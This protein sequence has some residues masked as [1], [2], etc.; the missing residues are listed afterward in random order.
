[1]TFVYNFINKIFVL[2]LFLLL[3]AGIVLGQINITQALIDGATNG[4]AGALTMTDGNDYILTENVALTGDWTNN[5][6]A[7]SFTHGGFTVTFSGSS[8]QDILGTNTT[9]FSGVTIN[10]STMI[11]D[12]SDEIITGTLTVANSEGTTGIYISNQTIGAVIVS[13]G[14]LRTGAGSG[15]YIGDVTIS[16]GTLSTLGDLRVTGNW[17]KTSGT[18][19]HNSKSTS[20]RGAGGTQTI[21]GSTTFYDLN[22]WNTGGVIDATGATVVVANRLHVIIGKFIG[23]PDVNGDLTIDVGSEFEASGNFTLAGEFENNDTFDATTNSAKITFDGSSNQFISG[24]TTF[25]DVELN[26]ST[27]TPN[28]SSHT[29][30]GTLTVIAG[31]ATVPTSLGGLSIAGGTVVLSG[32]TSISGDFNHSSG[33]FTQGG[34][35]VTMNGTAAQSMTGALSFSNLTINNT[36]VSA[37]VDA[38]GASSLAVS[39][40]LT[41]T[42]GNFKS[43]SDYTNVTIAAA[44]TLTL[45]GD[46]TVSGDWSN[47]GTL[48]GNYE[49][50]FDGTDTQNITGTTTFYNL[51][52]NNSHISNKVVASSATVIV[53]N[54]FVITD[55]IFSGAPDLLNSTISSSAG[56]LELTGNIKV[57]GNWSNTSGNLT[58]NYEVEFDGASSTITGATTFYNLKINNASNTINIST[59]SVTNLLTLT[60]GSVTGGTSYKNVTLNGGT[61]ILSGNTALSGNWIKSSGTF[62]PGSNEVEFTGASSTITGATSFY[63]LEINNASN[64][65]NISAHTVTNLLTITAGSVTGGTSY[66]NVTLN[67]G[68]FILSGNTTLTGSWTNSSG[69]FTPGSY[70]VEFT[71]AGS[72]ITGATTFYSLDINNASNT[73]NISA[74]SVSNTLTVT[75]GSVTGGTDYVNL[76]IAG[77]TFVLSGNTTISGNWVRTGGS[78]TPGSNKV[79][80][81]GSS[82][83]NIT[84]TNSFYDLTIANTHVSNKVN[85]S[86]G[87]ITVTNDLAVTDG[88]FLSASDYTNVTISV[89]ATLELSGNITVSGSWTNNGTFT[90]GSNAVTFDGSS[91]QNLLGATTFYQLVINNP[92]MT[93]NLSAHTISNKLTV[94]TSEGT[95]G[96]LTGSGT[97]PTV[98]I[99]AGKVIL[100]SGNITTLLDIDGGTVTLGTGTI[101][102]LD[103]DGGTTTSHATSGDF[104]IVDIATGSLTL[105]G[106]V[107]ISGSFTNA[108]DATTFIHNDKTITFDGATTVTGPSTFSGVTITGTLTLANAIVVKGDWTN[109][110]GTFTHGSQ[111]VTFSGSAAQAL[112]GGTNTFYNLTITSG[113]VVTSSGTLTVTTNLSV[114]TGTFVSASDYNNVTLASGTTL[115]LAGNITVSGTW[116]NNGGSLTGSFAVEFDG[117]ASQSIGGTG[118]TTFYNLTLNNSNGA[119]LGIGQRVNNTLTLTSGIITLGNFDLTFGD[120]ATAVAGTLSATKMIAVTGT[121]SVIKEFTGADP[122]LFLF[123]IGETSGTTEYSPFSVDLSGVT[124][125]GTGLVAVN[126]TDAAHGDVTG[127]D[128]L[129]RY[130]SVTQS[131]LTSFSAAIVGTYLTADIT[132]TEASIFGLKRDGG[133][134]WTNLGLVNAGANTI[135]GSGLTSFSDFTGGGVGVTVTAPNGGQRFLVNRVENI[136]WTFYNVTNVQID[137]STNNG[138]AWTPVIAST[139]AAAGT[140]AWTIPATLTTQ[141]LVRVSDATNAAVVNDVSNAVFTIADITVTTPNGAEFWEVA[142]SHDIEWDQSDLVTEVQIEYSTNT[143]GSW[144]V[145]DPSEV[146]AGT[147]DTFSWTIPNTPTATALVRVTALTGGTGSD[148]SDAVFIIP[149]VVVVAPNGGEAWVSGTS[150]DITYTTPGYTIGTEQVTITYS[151]DNGGS[152]MPLATPVT[153]GTYS[154]T[155]SDEHTYNALVEIKRVAGTS[156]DTSNAVFT[157]VPPPPPY[158]SPSAN[159]VAVTIEPTLTW[160]AVTNAVTYEMQVYSTATPS[161]TVIDTTGLLPAN[162]LE[163]DFEQ[164]SWMGGQNYY[165]R[166]KNLTGYLWRM[167]T[168]GLNSVVGNWSSPRKFTTIQGVTPTLTYPLTGSIL[169]TPVVQYY[170]NVTIPYNNLVFELFS[171]TTGDFT[172]ISGE[173]PLLINGELNTSGSGYSPGTLHYWMVRTKTH[174]GQTSSYS[175][176]ESFITNGLLSPITLL[177]PYDGIETFNN[178]PYVYWLNYLYSPLVKYQVRYSKNNSLDINDALDTDFTD[179]PLT[180]NSYAQLE[181][182]D[183]GATYY[184][185]VA[186][187]NDG[188]STLLWSDLF[189]FTTPASTSSNTF[190]APTPSYPVAGVTIYSTSSTYYWIPQTIDATLQYQ[191]RYGA[192]NA[193]TAGQLDA[194]VNTA[195]TSDYYIQVAGLTGNTTYYW[196]VRTY[197]GSS[198]SPWSVVQTFNTD[199]S[200]NAIKTPILLSPYDGQIVNNLQPTLYWYIDGS[201]AGYDYTVVYNTDGAQNTN[202]NLSGTSNV[203]GS[204]ATT[205]LLAKFA[206]DLTNGETYYW[207]VIASTGG[208]DSAYSSIKSFSVNA[209]STVSI[210]LPIPAYPVGGIVVNTS[211]PV[212]HWVVNG[213]YGHL[214]FQIRYST[215][216]TVSG[217]ILQNGTVDSDWTSNLSTALSGLTPGATYYWQVRARLASTPAT[218]SDYSTVQYF[219]ISAGASPV[220]AILGSPIDGVG[221]NTDT[222]T[223][224][225]ILPMSTEST[226][227]YDLEIADNADMTSAEKITGL[228]ETQF[229]HN[230]TIGKK[231]YWRVR[232]RNTEGE[233]SYY[234]GVGDF[235]IKS[236]ITETEDEEALPTEF[237]IDQNY[238]NPFNPSTS[239]RFGLPEA[240]KVRLSIYNILGEEIKTLVNEELDAGYH[241][242][243]WNAD[244][245]NGSKVVSG[246]YFY[247]IVSGNNLI[248]KK[249]L[250]I[251]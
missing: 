201:G 134:S 123:P 20:F 43:A 154:W 96:I 75:A 39:G 200:I 160:S 94:T 203:L 102:S 18:F 24:T 235:D 138:G 176:V 82:T 90:S 104:G 153:G 247:K 59:H 243:I 9:T 100:G 44:G 60:A 158:G 242:V 14:L 236:N 198:Y 57:S 30:E 194:G 212:V 167:R 240:S 101:A 58:G 199:A 244:N 224:S 17:T 173:S 108:S 28:F 187:T 208:A 29:I 38:S 233:Y 92:A 143:G 54:N 221:I 210:T 32:N 84:G 139:S 7:N 71:G 206:S 116:T 241:H 62:T 146:S 183:D 186:V 81:D 76:N 35:L 97:I 67:G 105:G 197:N 156:T 79:T 182:L 189:S 188:G 132:G 3:T 152:W 185:Q 207:Q 209:S 16:G 66:K 80:F 61:F 98:Q 145:V 42:D 26:N 41:I 56:T 155:V 229:K 72:T 205:H 249:M 184:W 34:F 231:Y 251:K 36:H 117:A 83:Q 89:G 170:W 45:S 213:A 219:V 245:N 47:S 21:S 142:S 95:T 220:M 12:L 174:A 192:S 40:T 151:T 111:N 87:S 78:F 112:T 15:T 172:P 127:A 204:G 181:D 248:T 140:Y 175:A 144:I 119:V 31:S 19:T 1:M 250:F 211:D 133:S 88:I 137:Y 232:S 37:L 169:S 25:Y 230:L 166:M 85:A 179:L 103:I 225:W 11:E 2:T 74:H 109:S 215:D 27:T 218:M 128:F 157:I 191:V 226:L 135:N 129:T 121:G 162:P 234:T 33:T 126:V 53:S 22:S 91:D 10:N 163:I 77:G 69:T 202:G 159:E 49:V 124:Y 164:L 171:N 228:T 239:I 136:T 68:T 70:E 130:W 113:D 237:S 217:G 46:I 106:P 13:G 147:S 223:L 48:S 86:T 125:G 51:E 131:N 193:T 50:Q 114:T 177:Y 107:A 8:D 178:M 55:G 6:S 148:V 196:Q 195:L 180:F 118:S 4:P 214:E 110:T 227:S 99:I 73:I 141:A 23:A 52:I 238:P 5:L 216:N 120:A 161:E 122:A 168:I 165:T 93:E 64:T 150:E 246:A 65:I 115:Q 190:L 63:D 149:G 222:P